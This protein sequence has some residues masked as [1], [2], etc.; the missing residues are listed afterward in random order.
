[1]LFRLALA[2]DATKKGRL[3]ES[4]GRERVAHHAARAVERVSLPS[5]TARNKSASLIC[6]P[7]GHEAAMDAI[8][9]ANLAYAAQPLLV[10]AGTADPCSASVN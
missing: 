7:A 5:P 4:T 1:M 3:L 8:V 9:L 2:K 10:D 6:S